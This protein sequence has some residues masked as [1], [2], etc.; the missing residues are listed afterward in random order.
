[1]ALQEMAYPIKFAG[2]VST[3]E[4]PK[5]VPTAR[6]LTLENAVFTRAEIGRAHV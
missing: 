1:M 3:K 5:A 2:G 4:D 6:L